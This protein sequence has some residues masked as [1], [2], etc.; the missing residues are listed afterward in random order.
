MKNNER[1]IIMTNLRQINLIVFSINTILCIALHNYMGA[2]G[3]LCAAIYA[4]PKGE[5]YAS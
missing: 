5:K 1:K 2:M 3:W 4:Y